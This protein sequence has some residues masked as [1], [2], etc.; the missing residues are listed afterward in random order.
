MA[1]S[2]QLTTKY[3]KSWSLAT[4]G[5][6]F[7]LILAAVLPNLQS[8]VLHKFRVRSSAIHNL[9][10]WPCHL[11]LSRLIIT[12]VDLWTLIAVFAGD[13]L[14]LTNIVLYM[15]REVIQR[16]DVGAIVSSSSLSQTETFDV[17][18]IF[19]LPAGI[20][21]PLATS[22]N[23]C[24]DRFLAGFHNHVTSFGFN[25]DVASD[26]H[27]ILLHNFL[28]DKGRRLQHLRL[29][30]SDSTRGRLQ[31]VSKRIGNFYTHCANV[32]LFLSSG[33]RYRTQWCQP[34]PCAE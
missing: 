14:R 2:L 28:M 10:R 5:L 4:D 9:P 34:A 23:I 31:G 17:D 13:S 12:E 8:L 7:V 24:P 1:T 25:C 18:G 11:T 26:D 20:D 21:N 16:D 27:V 6:A 29:N 3:S 32:L 19:I 33:A 15:D 22:T 30:L